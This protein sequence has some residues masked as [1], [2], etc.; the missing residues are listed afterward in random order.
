MSNKNREGIIKKIISTL[1]LLSTFCVAIAF[2]IMLP[3]IVGIYNAQKFYTSVGTA[4]PYGGIALVSWIVTQLLGYLIPR[5]IPKET[6]VKIG[7]IM[8]TDD[9][10]IPCK[11]C[12]NTITKGAQYCPYC[13]RIQE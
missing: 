7:E 11:Y 1:N 13:S 12:K 8:V 6:N 4:L 3:Q 10:Q 5:A 9:T 2:L